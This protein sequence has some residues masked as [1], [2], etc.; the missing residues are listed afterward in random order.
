VD[1]LDRSPIFKIKSRTQD[2]VSPDDFTETL[3]QWA[4]IE[5]SGQAND[6]GRVVDSDS[7]CKLIQKPDALLGKRERQIL[8][9]FDRQQ[10]R[11]GI[12]RYGPGGLD[13]FGQFDDN[14]FFEETGEG[15]FDS[16]YFA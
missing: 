6:T 12:R 1:N 4:K 3:F 5:R 7:G 10:R 9:A 16:E 8:I 13:L 2:F 15:D 11:G 14:R